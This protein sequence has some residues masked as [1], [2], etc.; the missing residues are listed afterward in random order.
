MALWCV[1]S[2]GGATIDG[3]VRIPGDPGTLIVMNHQSLIDIPLLVNLVMDGYPKIVTRERYSR[4]IPLISYMLRLCEHP[5][6]DPGRHVDANMRRLREVA[7][8]TSHPILIFPEG[9]RTRDG[10]IKPFRTAGLQAILS[11]R[12]WKVY[13]VVADGMWKCGKLVDFIRNIGSVRARVECVGPIESPAPGEDP[14]EFITGIRAIMC[15]KLHEMRQG[16]AGSVA[17]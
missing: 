1:R 10:E 12:S 6:V 16:T 2:V 14:A 17:S 8:T 4:G 13:V 15:D 11:A 3:R 7:E 5:L 9:S